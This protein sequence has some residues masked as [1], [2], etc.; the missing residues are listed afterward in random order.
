[1]SSLTIEYESNDMILDCIFYEFFL[2]SWTNKWD[3]SL[4]C[5]S[6][7]FVTGDFNK[8]RWDYS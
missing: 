4:N 6:T 1:M 8:S 5:M 7:L 3:Q 2:K